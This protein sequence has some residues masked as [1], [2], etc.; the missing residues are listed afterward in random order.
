MQVPPGGAGEHDLDVGVRNLHHVLLRGG[1][2]DPV[3]PGPGT[4]PLAVCVLAVPPCLPYKGWVGHR[5]AYA[6]AL[7][8]PTQDKLRFT[9]TFMSFVD[10]ITIVPVWL[11]VYAHTQMN[12]LEPASREIAATLR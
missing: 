5:F 6:C 8:P 11:D 2:L 4:N 3:L 12:G 7:S 9:F 1:L 10:V